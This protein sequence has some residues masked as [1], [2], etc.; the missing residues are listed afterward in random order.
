MKFSVNKSEL[1]N[2]LSI[3]QKGTSPRALLPVLSGI[4][5]EAK[6]NELIIQSTNLE[7]SIQYII[8]ALIE[9]E[10]SIVV[11]SKL[12]LEIIKNC[13]DVALSITIENEYAE[14]SFDKSLFT[15]KVLSAELFPIFP[16]KDTQEEIILPFSQFSKMIKKVSKVVSKD[17]T[18]INLTGILIS[19]QDNKLRMVATDAYRLAIVD[20]STN[21]P[22]NTSFKA[23]I[24]GA[25]LQDVANLPPNADE[26]QIG[27]SESQVVIKYDRLILINRRIEGTFPPYEELLPH[28]HT[29]ETSIKR[30]EL[31][32]A[33]KRVSL[34]GSSTIPISFDIN[35]ESQTLRVSSVAQDIGEASEI[36]SCSC[37]GEDVSIS[38]NYSYVLEGL[39][40]AST[41]YINLETESTLKPGIFKTN[42]EQPYTYLVMPVRI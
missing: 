10:G 29:T 25:F 35:I 28:S 18:R 15:I 17:E 34:L 14:V 22:C 37:T 4:Y 12:F 8:P 40:N 2:A 20:S 23:I 9:K 42:G 38:F 21:I 41:D 39:V 7:L 16:F 31:I 1:Q 6:E 11:P 3:V 26:I 32:T 27:L 30:E 13:S 24:S 33:I 5:I 19:Y 36:I